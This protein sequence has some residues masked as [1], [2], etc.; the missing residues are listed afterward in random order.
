MNWLKDLSDVYEKN[1]PL[2]GIYQKGRYGEP[3][4]L[5]PVYHTTMAA[6]IT[7]ILDKEGRFLRADTVAEE[8]KLTVV[9]VTELSA[10]RSTNVAP[11][12]LCEYLKYLARDYADFLPI[13]QQREREKG[14]YVKYMRQLFAWV[15]S[16]YNHPKVQA[17]CRYLWKAEIIQDLTASGC[18][19][20][21]QDGKFDTGQKIQGIPQADAFIRFIVI[22]RGQKDM[23]GLEKMG[24]AERCWMDRSLQEMY[25]RYVRAGQK[26]RTLSC[27]SGEKTAVTYLHPK[28]I[29]NESDNTK[30]ISAND[31]RGG[32]LKRRF[33]C[34]EQDF[35]V[36]YEES[37]KAHNALKWLIRRQGRHYGSLCMVAW[38]TEGMEIPPWEW[39][40][41]GAESQEGHKE[42]APQGDVCIAAF[43]SASKGRLA[44]VAYERLPGSVWAENMR[45]WQTECGWLYPDGYR[46]LGVEEMARMLYGDDS[47]G[48]F[49]IKKKPEDVYKML[50]KR[51]YP[52]VLHR[53]P[54]P[55]DLLRLAVARASMPC[56][57]ANQ[58]NWVLLLSLACALMKKHYLDAGGREALGLTLKEACT[59]RSYLYG[60]LLAVADRIESLACQRGEMCMTNAK[61]YMEQFSRAPYQTWGHLYRKAMFYLPHL[62]EEKAVVCEGL[63]RKILSKFEEGDLEK[64]KPL[65]GWYLLGYYHQANALRAMGKERREDKKD[66]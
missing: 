55:G 2:A 3:L 37:Q 17:I 1:E 36:G 6:Q 29:R 33:G 24:E 46:T 62:E 49:E 50:W 12:P 14:R 11:M 41:R 66:E 61:R 16:E 18:L 48:Y 22:D 51:L 19:K 47:R 7:I 38:E 57:Y 5:L 65:L 60:R 59:E 56:R 44:I 26:A 8:E 45:R 58:K 9:P 25:I 39:S 15:K 4:I 54:L 40:E 35:A 34:R 27:V 30:L 13:G 23:G 20:L 10:S 63:I 53:E 52:C 21:G 31:K 64:G 43:D 42:R 32:Y 28:K